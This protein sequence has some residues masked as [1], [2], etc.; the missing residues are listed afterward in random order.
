MQA[1]DWTIAEK[2]GLTP[3]DDQYAD[4]MKGFKN[5]PSKL[6]R[7]MSW[8][9]RPEI[10]MAG[11]ESLAISVPANKAAVLKHFQARMPYGARRA[12]FED[13][14]IA[15]RHSAALLRKPAPV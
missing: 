12:G 14:L 11:G 5:A 13:G 6:E 10:V 15:D 1:V 8:M 4:W 2:A 7:L 3:A 9:R